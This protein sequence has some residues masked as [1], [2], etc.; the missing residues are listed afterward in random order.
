MLHTGNHSIYFN[1]KGV[2]LW[3][4]F[5]KPQHVTLQAALT[6][7][8]TAVGRSWEQRPLE[9]PSNLKDSATLYSGPAKATAVGPGY[10]TG[11]V[12][13]LKET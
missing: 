5:V 8:L 3:N 2:D 11:L 6:F 1:R 7:P 10:L 4:I 13:V 12:Y 9:I